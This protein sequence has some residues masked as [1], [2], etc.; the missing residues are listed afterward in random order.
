MTDEDTDQAQWAQQELEER[1]RREDELLKRIREQ[2]GSFRAECD[3]FN[4]EFSRYG[5]TTGERNAKGK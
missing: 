5:Y 4:A 2:Y 1:H 3:D